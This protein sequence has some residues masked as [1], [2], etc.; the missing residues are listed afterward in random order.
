MKHFPLLF[1]VSYIF[2]ASSPAFSATEMESNTTTTELKSFEF[3]VNGLALAVGAAFRGLTLPMGFDFKLG[4]RVALGPT[5]TFSTTNG[6]S[7]NHYYNAQS[8]QIDYGL[9]FTAYPTRSFEDGGFLVRLQAGGTHAWN[10][11]NKI[12]AITASVLMGWRLDLGDHLSL[13]P[14]IG[15]S[16]FN[17][18]NGDSSSNN[19]FAFYSDSKTFI[20][21]TLQGWI[22]LVF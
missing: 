17:S 21:A 4:N 18:V 15:I 20:T 8:A 3:R 11:T 10:K 6:R 2:G 12:D 9:A 5:I 1:F 16:T 14:S 22:G 7:F 13:T 19:R